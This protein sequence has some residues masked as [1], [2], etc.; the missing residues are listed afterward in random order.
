[1]NLGATSPDL[2]S[3]PPAIPSADELVARIRRYFPKVDAGYV[4]RAYAFAEEAHRPQRRQSGEPYFAHVAQVAMILADLRMDLAT[5]C[6]GLLHDTVED[7]PATL[8]DITREFGEETASLVDGVTKLGQMELR[9]KRTKQAENL[10]KLVVAISADVRVLIVKLC[11]R[12]HNMRTLGAIPRQDKRERI[13]RETLE[14]YAPLAR[15]IGINRVCVELEDLAFEHINPAAHESIT[16]RLKLLREQHAQEVSAVSEAIT[17]R[18]AR[19]GIEARIF[20]REKRP[21]SIWRKLERK[22]LTFE[23]IADIYAFRL[24]V[25][26]PDECY[27]ALG[28]IHQAW[29]CMPER[30]RDFISLPKPNNY[31]SLHTTVIGPHNVR[32]ELQIRT[33]E[34]EAVAESGVAAHW[35]YKNS[36]YTYDPDAA[37]AAGGDPLERLRPFVEILNQGGDP[38]EFLEHAK[39]EMFADQVYC[40]TPKGD[41]ISLPA[42]ATPLDFAYAVHTELGHTTVAAK[43]NGRERPLRTQL[44]NGDVVQ[45]VKG[46]VRQPPQGWENLAITGRARAAIRRLIRESEREEFERIGRIMAEHA[47]RREGRQLVETD[48]GDALARLDLKDA[49]ELYENL[50]RGRVSS[51]DLLNAAFPG[52]L[53]ERG[54]VTER[55]LIEDDK[56]RLFVRGRGLTPGVTLHF[57]DCCS[58]LPGDRIV[59]LLVPEKGVE[60]HTIDCET[61]AGHEEDD[62]DRWLDLAWTAEAEDNA[63][64]IAR[65]EAVLHNGQGVLAEIAKTVSENRGNIASVKTRRRSTDFFDMEFDVEVF[66]AR[67]LAN[68]LAALRMCPSVVS[69]ERK[70]ADHEEIEE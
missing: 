38:D 32:V 55:E 69:A 19:A 26:A 65:I 10:Q 12:L 43:I 42:G 56:A 37:Q 67:H 16:K 48:L 31:R 35:R 61:L 8:D 50:G 68:I 3:P 7:T 47:F 58:P 60:V 63:V 9:S 46:G 20:G 52:R 1:M 17:D 27:R 14:I 13:A 6:T 59:G 51:G 24:I 28:V 34:M 23:E 15:R 70:R 11:D 30:F 4:R 33:E 2:A 25:S 53:E 41:L 29:R 5:V 39:L 64:S 40:F 49:D 54:D 44:R 66:D 57:A 18:L 22:G 45:I 62:M 21:Y 36:A